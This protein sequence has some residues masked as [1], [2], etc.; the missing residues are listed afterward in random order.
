MEIQLLEVTE[1]NLWNGSTE[2]MSNHWET[3][4]THVLPGSETQQ[5]KHVL[6]QELRPSSLSEELFH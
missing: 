1:C 5:H 6:I 2:G 3:T 4:Q